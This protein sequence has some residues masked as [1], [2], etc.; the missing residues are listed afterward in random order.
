M[1]FQSIVLHG[2]DGREEELGRIKRFVHKLIPVMYYRTTD[3]L[4]SRRVLWHLENMIPDI[5]SV[6]G[7][8]F[9]V[10]FARTLALVHD[11]VEIIT[12]DPQ[13]YDKETMDAAQLELLVQREREAIPGLVQMYGAIANGYDYKEL[14]T[15][16][17]NK[18]RIESQFVSLCDK[19]DGSGESSH[20][21]WAGNKHF[22]LPAGGN[23]GRIRG[24]VRRQRE[25]QIK[26]P[27]MAR[28]FEIFPEY[29]PS[30]FDF[31]NVAEHGKL[32]T[33]ESIQENSGYAHYDRWRRTIIKREG[34]DNLITQLEFE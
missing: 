14:L 34:I 32:H 25:F 12:G 19:F 6:Y 7:S 10:N 3:F 17:K 15:S 24:Y 16:A 28:F 5:L 18:D 31:N 9:D 13:L 11:D 21:V 23:Q 22:L 29:L 2:F 26:Y 33:A 30:P 4:H 1:D 20:E 27:A 8:G